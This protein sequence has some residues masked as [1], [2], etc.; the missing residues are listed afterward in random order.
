[1][2]ANYKYTVNKDVKGEVN[3]HKQEGFN[4]RRMM[5]KSIK[6]RNDLPT[7]DLVEESIKELKYRTN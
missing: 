4:W 5:N 7:K 3:I 2:D 1:M 6:K